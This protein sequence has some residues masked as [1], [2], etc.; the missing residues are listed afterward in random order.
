MTE[1]AHTLRHTSAH[2]HVDRDVLRKP[3]KADVG[4]ITR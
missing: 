1:A 2:R 3:E 4:A